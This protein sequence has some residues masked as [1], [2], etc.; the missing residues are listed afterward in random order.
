MRIGTQDGGNNENHN[1]TDIS[2]LYDI[3]YHIFKHT[4][5]EITT[6]KGRHQKVPPEFMEVNMSNKNRKVGD[7]EILSS[8]Y[9]GEYEIV[10]CENSKAP[11]D[12]VFL[13]GYLEDNGI[14]VRLSNC[15]VSGSYAE[16]A[17][18]FGERV[19]E[20]SKE[21]QKELERIEENIGSDTELKEDD[22]V[23]D[24]YKNSI[25]GKIVIL[26][27]DILR[28]EYRRASSQLLLCTGGFGAQANARGRSCFATRL[29]DGEN[30]QFKRE[31]VLGT[32][33]EEKLPEW[34]KNRLEAIRLQH[35][36][37]NKTKDTRGDSR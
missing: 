16:I 22:C 11:S 17:E 1:Y 7:Y 15:L 26:K 24:S 32:I 6:T 29:Y 35:T 9:I 33:P 28:P 12:K 20:K 18:I 37:Q 3:R 10:L 27:G 34:A 5:K 23:P 21:V 25:E 8:V 4:K 19:T 36:N 14:F 30:T 13:C 31:D 2:R